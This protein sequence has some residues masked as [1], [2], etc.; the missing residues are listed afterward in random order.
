MQQQIHAREE[1]IMRS[2]VGLGPV[3]KPLRLRPAVTH[4]CMGRGAGRVHT[5]DGLNV[6]L[7]GRLLAER[8]G[9]ARA[10]SSG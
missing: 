3:R 7:V 4:G 10:A 1:G 8:R 2:G 6:R 9:S 5:F